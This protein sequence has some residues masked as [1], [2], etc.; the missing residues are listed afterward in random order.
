MATTSDVHP[1]DD[2]IAYPTNRVVGTIAD[3]QHARAAI[4]ALLHAGFA[5]QDIDILHGEQDLHRPEVPGTEH[6]FLGQFQRTV[7]QKLAGE[8]QAPAPR[9]GVRPPP[10]LHRRR[11]RGALGRHG[12]REEAG[13]A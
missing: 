9:G 11:P 2:F 4:E 8:V 6:R 12:G 7:I 13:E 5:Q 1:P 10:A 3:P